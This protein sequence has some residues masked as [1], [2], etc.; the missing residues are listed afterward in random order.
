[1]YIT[2]TPQQTG[3]NFSQSVANYVAYL[4]KENQNRTEQEKELFFDQFS[5]TIAP[6]EVIKEIDANTKRLM[7]KEPKFY[8]ITLSP[9]QREL[10]H[11]KNPSQD[12]KDYTRKVMEA[13]VESFNR[14]IHGRKLTIDDIKY[15]A[16]IEHKRFYNHKD[17]A[18]RLN[19]PIASQILELQHEL[20]KVQRGESQADPTVL[21][22][23][24]NRWEATAPQKINGRRIA[25]GMEKPGLQTHVHIIVSRRDASNSVSLSPGSKYRA[26][27]VKMHGKTVKRGFDR[28]TFFGNAEKVF[29]KEFG[30]RRKFIEQYTTRKLF[31]SRPKQF[32][33]Q[34]MGLP[35]AERAAVL[36]M[37][38]KSGISIPNV[39]ANLA[40]LGKKAAKALKKGMGKAV[41]SS[42]IGI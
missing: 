35:L 13:Y 12:L 26:S 37:M 28:N 31:R 34:L 25:I 24:I 39:P 41:N 6:K 7:K 8:T 11:L 38:G 20:R 30:Y 32:M 1:M 42:S 18:V 40:Q 16:K 3:G 36:K 22:T 33:A 19:Q 5:D 27:E 29:D 23:E 14:E 17:E 2:I 21:R 10:Q 15:Y 4:E 9:S